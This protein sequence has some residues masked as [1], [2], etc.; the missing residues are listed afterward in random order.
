MVFLLEESIVHLSPTSRGSTKLE[1]VK[2]FFLSEM[3]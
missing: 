1:S 3:H 2:R